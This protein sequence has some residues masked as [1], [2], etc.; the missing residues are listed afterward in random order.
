[1]TRRHYM[2]GHITLH[3]CEA[4]PPSSLKCSFS[5]FSTP[6]C[7]SSFG[8]RGTGGLPE[9]LR[10]LPHHRRRSLR[11]ATCGLAWRPRPARR[12]SSGS[13]RQQAQ[14]FQWGSIG[15]VRVILAGSRTGRGPRSSVGWRLCNERRVEGLS[16]AAVAEGGSHTTC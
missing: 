15:F 2:N 11:P 9:R 4:A 1:M 3:E 8:C 16:S 14:Y 10:R 6:L 13:C 12:H 7:G 5:K